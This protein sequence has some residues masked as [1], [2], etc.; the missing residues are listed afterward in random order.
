MARMSSNPVI[1][2]TAGFR[3]SKVPDESIDARR[4]ARA[5]G[6]DHHIV[7]MTAEY[8]WNNAPRIADAL[9]DPT[10]D[11]ATIPTFALAEAARNRVKVVL[12]GE[13]GD[14]MFCGYSRYRRA[15]WLGGMFTR[16]ARTRGELDALGTTNGALRGWR[17]GLNEVEREEA[18]SGRT[19]IQQLQA[20]DCAEWL[21]NDLL[22]KLDR[23]LMANGIE[24]RTP[25]LDPVVA[26][27][28]MRLP[29]AMKAT[30]RMSKRILRDWLAANVPAA[31]PY[32]KKLGFNPPIGEWIAVRKSL[33]ADLVAEAPGIAEAFSR[34]DVD[35]VFADPET[36]HQAAWSMLFYALWHSRHILGV[37]SGGNVQDVLTAAR[38]YA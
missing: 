17:D 12:S 7:E 38:A 22:I 11:A 37:S 28:A 5:V 21:P 9:D 2:L 20:V 32:A 15:R 6:A 13:G 8:F 24:G 31:E 30:R 27:F 19:F 10:T 16:H 23:C 18:A 29:D 33:V 34:A 4:V 25:F 3:D 26:E 36:N 14:E 1:A 35:R